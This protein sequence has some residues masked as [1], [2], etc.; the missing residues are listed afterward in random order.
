[1]VELSPPL[2]QRPGQSALYARLQEVSR[3]RPLPGLLWATITDAQGGR[4][5][6][7]PVTTLPIVREGWI[8]LHFNLA[9]ARCSE[10]LSSLQDLPQRAANTLVESEEFQQLYIED[11][12]VFGMVADLCRGLGET[13]DH[14]G[15]LHF[16]AGDGILITARRPPIAAT[17]SLRDMMRKGQKVPS[18]LSALEA[19]IEQVV[20]GFDV[21][22]DKLAG[23]VDS[24]ED[25]I[26]TGSLR[27]VRQRLS[28]LR[29]TRVRLYRHISGL[30][31]LFRR[32]ERDRD[33]EAEEDLPS[34][35]PVFTISNR[36]L[37]RVDQLDHDVSVLG[38]R[39][40]MLQDEV[41]ALR[42][43]ET[44]RHLRVLSILTIIFMPP[45]FLAGLLG[46]NLKGIPFAESEKGFWEGTALTILSAVLIVWLMRRVGV[47][48]SNERD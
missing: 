48:R 10:L 11:G 22:V 15:F 39:T 14:F 28:E 4:T 18:E 32:L 36:I 29:R 13:S 34:P 3:G 6:P 24:L 25:Q 17:H 38:E 37:Q 46:M 5:E 16:L 35:P 23:T 19:L 9:D 8:W 20:E 27:G 2:L 44:N 31:V 42:T 40:R 45:T 1:M 21:F 33:R 47:I 12:F 7:N 30:R 26:I 43:E 41:A